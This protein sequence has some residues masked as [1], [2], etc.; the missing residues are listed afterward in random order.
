MAF[1]RIGG[2]IAGKNGAYYNISEEDFIACCCAGL[3][4]GGISF[5]TIGS[6]DCR[7]EAQGSPEIKCVSGDQTIDAALLLAADYITGLN[8]VTRCPT[9]DNYCEGFI[10]I[11][12]F[13]SAEQ[14]ETAYYFKWTVEDCQIPPIDY[15]ATVTVVKC[16]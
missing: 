13:V 2:G 8:Y 1:Y 14:D 3:K 4:I 5:V 10:P 15:E 12:S 6:P 11:F 16:P 9:P 7:L